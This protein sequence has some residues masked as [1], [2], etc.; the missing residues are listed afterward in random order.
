MPYAGWEKRK[1]EGEKKT[2]RG[3]LV[4][5]RGRK[6]GGCFRNPFAPT[7]KHRWHV[8]EN[9][10]RGN[11]IW[12]SIAIASRTPDRRYT[13]YFAPTHTRRRV[14]PNE[15][16]PTGEDAIR[17]RKPGTYKKYDYPYVALL[18]QQAWSNPKCKSSVLKPWMQ[19][20]RGCNQKET[21]V[22]GVTSES[23]Y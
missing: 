15:N 11:N 8:D 6:P 21:F 18:R 22:K 12:A 5:I 4:A 19:L 2:S 13:N 14:S 7:Y 9:D 3:A 1:T 23:G 10:L 16:R 17:G 20:K